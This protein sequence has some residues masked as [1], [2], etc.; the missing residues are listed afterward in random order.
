MAKNKFKDIKTKDVKISDKKF[1]EVG[2]KEFIEDGTQFLSLAKYTLNDK[3]LR[4]YSVIRND[5]THKIKEMHSITIKKDKR[6]V[7]DLIATI[8]E[9]CL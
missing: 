4:K 8:K 7:E 6:I 3:G 5:G 2:I 9:C 1:I